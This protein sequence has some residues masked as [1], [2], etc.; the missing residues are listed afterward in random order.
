MSAQ[1]F[2]LFI[3]VMLAFHRFGNSISI[4]RVANTRFTSMNQLN[5]DSHF[6]F[7]SHCCQL[8][9]AL[10]LTYR[11]EMNG[12]STLILFKPLPPENLAPC[13]SNLSWLMTR[14]NTTSQMSVNISKPT[15]LV[16]DGNDYLV[17]LGYR[18]PLIQFNRTTLNIIQSVSVVTDATSINYNNGFYYISNCSSNC[19]INVLKTNNLSTIIASIPVATTVIHE[20]AFIRNNSL[21]IV[22]ANTNNQTLLFDVFSTRNYTSSTPSYITTNRPCTVHAVNDTFI[23]IASWFATTTLTSVST[24]TYTNGT[25]TLTPLPN[26]TP[27]DTQKIF[28]TTIDSCGRLWLAVTGFG[29][30]IYDPWGNSLLYAWSVTSGINGFLLSD[31]YDVYIADFS[32]N[33][34]LYYNPNISQCTS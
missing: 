25:W 1:D 30:R 11:M 29:I 4:G 10:P 32:A 6:L 15:F 26:T 20:I 3:I 17:T 9:T 8:F 27:T 16:F 34:I 21:I 22:A 23:Y 31:H 12:N 2:E 19:V 28:Q 14:I 18:G 24:L 5:Q 7:N 33:K 13:C